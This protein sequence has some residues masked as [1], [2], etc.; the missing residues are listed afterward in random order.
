MESTLGQRLKKVIDHYNYSMNKAAIAMDME[1][2]TFGKAVKDQVKPSYE[3]TV[4]IKKLF[5]E[6]N[7]EWLLLGEGSMFVE[8][9]TVVAEPQESYGVNYKEKYLECSEKYASALEELRS[10]ES[11]SRQSQ[12]QA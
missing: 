11:G 7:A 10:Y 5:P 6:V 3:L 12:K 8:K 2:Q 4:K 9:Q 1:A